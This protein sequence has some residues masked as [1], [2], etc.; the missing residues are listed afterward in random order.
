MHNVAQL[1]GIIDQI[2][3]KLNT[4]PRKSLNFQC[5]AEILMPEPFDF[6]KHF[7]H[8]ALGT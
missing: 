3:W 2:A 5:P 7:A 8:V 6:H 1:T 4:R